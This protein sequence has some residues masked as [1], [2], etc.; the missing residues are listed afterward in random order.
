MTMRRSDQTWLEQQILPD[1]RGIGRYLLTD[2]LHGNDGGYAGIVRNL[3]VRI[4]NRIGVE[5]TR[6]Y[7][8]QTNSELA[9][10]VVN[11]VADM[12][13][14]TNTRA[15]LAEAASRLAAS[16]IDVVVVD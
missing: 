11:A 15:L 2:P 10:S 12:N 16:E 1:L 3:I 7:E 6:A 8:T 14:D 5:A 13:V 9:E 4:E